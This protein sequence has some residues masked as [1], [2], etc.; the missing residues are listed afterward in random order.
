MFSVVSRMPSIRLIY[1]VSAMFVCVGAA[2]DTLFKQS[3]RLLRFITINRSGLLSHI[4]KKSRHGGGVLD[5]GE[6]LYELSAPEVVH[7]RGIR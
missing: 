6:I 4:P 7:A 1:A 2:Q 5:S 3:S